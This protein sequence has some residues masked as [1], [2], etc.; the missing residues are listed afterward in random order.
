MDERPL[1]PYNKALFIMVDVRLINILRVSLPGCVTPTVGSANLLLSRQTLD[2][3]G[4]PLK[5]AGRT[6]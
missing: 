6:L 1:A 2:V 3:Q 4:V 5:A